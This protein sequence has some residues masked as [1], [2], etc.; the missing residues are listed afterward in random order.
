MI[1]K[2]PHFGNIYHDFFEK[3]VLTCVYLF[4][5]YVLRHWIKNG[6]QGNVEF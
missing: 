5:S 6:K 3:R 2:I 1:S 4:V